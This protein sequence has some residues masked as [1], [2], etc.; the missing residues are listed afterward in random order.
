M[1]IDATIRAAAREKIN[2]ARDLGA[3]VDDVEAAADQ[4]V[5]SKAYID[6]KHN[7]TNSTR[8]STVFTI[9][10]TGLKHSRKSR[11]TNQEDELEFTMYVLSLV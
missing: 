10:V 4:V 3:V 5:T 2:A 11:N 7:L 6:R 8:N 9:K 1:K